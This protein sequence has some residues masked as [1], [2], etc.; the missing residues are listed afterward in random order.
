MG[1]METT[2]VAL[3]SDQKEWFKQ[4]DLNKSAWI[5]TKIDEEM[6]K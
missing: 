6:S 1:K 4:K 3:R 2:S 5:R